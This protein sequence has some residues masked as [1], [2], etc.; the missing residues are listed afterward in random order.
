MKIRRLI[1][2][3]SLGMT[4][5]TVMTHELGH[6]IGLGHEFTTA[7]KKALGS[8]MGYADINVITDADKATLKNLYPPQ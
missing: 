7:T 1:L 4:L 3:V 8:I 6:F 2:V 5:N